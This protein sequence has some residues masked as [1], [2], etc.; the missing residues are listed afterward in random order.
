M[1]KDFQN[2]KVV[3]TYDAHIRKLIPAYELMH[4]QVR[5][6]FGVYLQPNA[7][8]LIVGCGTG[9]EIQYLLQH[10]PQL[11]ITAVD[12]S[13]T[14]LE[15]AQNNLPQSCVGQVHFVHGTTADLA[16]QPQFDA[17]LS[18]LVAHFIADKTQFFEQIYQRLKTR[19][20]LMT[21]DLLLQTEPDELKVL[22]HTCQEQG[23]TT[24]QT[25]QMLI[26]LKDDFVL[27][28]PDQYQNVLQQVGF[29]KTKIYMQV[30]NYFGFLAQK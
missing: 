29:R 21:Y 9:Y 15:Q 13:L 16:D 14:M 11:N 17:A 12:P 5:A 26:R 30:I 27:I 3:A 4:A 2:P 6:N 19:A 22:Q 18:L 24:A 7:H 8:V 10:F 20:F 1:A 28:S 23:L 25:E